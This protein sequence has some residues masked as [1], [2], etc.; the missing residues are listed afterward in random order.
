[1]S[2]DKTQNSDNNSFNTRLVKLLSACKLSQLS[3]AKAIGISQSIIS[4]WISG[5]KNPRLPA[6]ESIAKETGANLNWLILGE[7]PMFREGAGI[8][9]TIPTENLP[10][11][12]FKRWLDEFWLEADPDQR[13]W[14]KVELREKIPK[15]ADWL[16]KMDERQEG[17]SRQV[18]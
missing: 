17:G 14:L 6:L 13:T 12:Q 1:M 10:K 7:G 9:K 3:L 15:F 16:K 8:E 5:K 18:G 11:E 4:E 2:T